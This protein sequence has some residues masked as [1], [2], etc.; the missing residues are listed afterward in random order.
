MPE[1]TLVWNPTASM[2]PNHESLVI[3]M[4]LNGETIYGIYDQSKGFLYQDIPINYI[5]SHW[6]YQ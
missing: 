3:W 2:K 5:P 4:G 1:P 6:R